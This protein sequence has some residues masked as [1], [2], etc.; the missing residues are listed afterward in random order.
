[1]LT[2]FQHSSIAFDGQCAKYAADPV[3]YWNKPFSHNGTTMVLGD[4]ATITFPVESDPVFIEMALAALKGLDIA[5]WQTVLG[6][7]CFV[8]LWTYNSGPKIYKADTDMTAWDQQFIAKNPA[9]YN[10]WYWHADKGLFDKNRWYCDQFNLNFGAT[11]L[12]TADIPAAACAYLFIDS[13]DGIVIN[14]AGLAARK[15]VFEQWPISKS[16]IDDTNQIS[17]GI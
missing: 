1:M 2:R 9:W 10:R 11:H 3:T 8:T 6:A 5:I 4:L 13:A 7:Q 16:V 17:G 14:S 12:H 15:A